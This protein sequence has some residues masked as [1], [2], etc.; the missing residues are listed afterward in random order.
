MNESLETRPWLNRTLVGFSLASFLSD[1]AHEMI[2]PLLPAFL[3]TLMGAHS[4]AGA[5]GIIMG[6]SDAAASFIKPVSG[7]ISDYLARRKPLVVIGYGLGAVTGLLAFAHQV[8]TV[9]VIKTT[10]W[11]GKGL[12]EPVRDAVIADM[13]PQK[14]YGRAYGFQR[15]M[16]TLGALTGPLLAFWLIS[17]VSVR[18]LF[19]LSSIP[20]LCAVLAIVWFT[21]DYF[22]EHEKPQAEHGSRW[23]F[24][25]T[26]SIFLVVMLLF[27]IAFFNRS[28]LVLYTQTHGVMPAHFSLEQWVL[29]LYTLCN[30]V[31]ALSEYGI[32]WL[33]DIMGRRL[34]FIMAGFI[35]FIL[36][37]GGMFF[38]VTH[39]PGQVALFVLMGISL[40]IVNALERA[41]A[42]D[43]LPLEMRATG[44]GVLQ[45]ASG[46]GYI[47]SSTI[48]GLLWSSL[49]LKIALVYAG[50]LAG[51][52]LMISLLWMKQES[53][54]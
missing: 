27:R 22:S 12:R 2:V 40:A 50:I 26:F 44:F 8:W 3:T 7:F 30:V 11:L 34:P 21:R 29:A 47:F 23:L 43:I 10:A 54:R 37:I 1:C 35:A 48:F 16:D 36:V 6:I 17:F 24:S 19:A 45:F 28:F 14:F 38:G 53:V 49:S 33:S 9:A 46:F 39:I 52:A 20:S 5:L 42:A 51:S 25:S 41:Y 18:G 13:I 15:A 4:V 31:R 32:G